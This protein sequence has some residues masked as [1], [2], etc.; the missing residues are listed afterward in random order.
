M[1]Y[2][3]AG[4]V[5]PISTSTPTASRFSVT[6]MTA[7]AGTAATA[8]T[9]PAFARKLRIG[10][11]VAASQAAIVSSAVGCS[12]SIHATTRAWYGRLRQNAYQMAM[13]LDAHPAASMIHSS[14]LVG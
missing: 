1:A 10:R 13:R 8:P 6:A 4:S 14:P 3:T 5:A 11:L 9:M 7:T 12:V 2:A